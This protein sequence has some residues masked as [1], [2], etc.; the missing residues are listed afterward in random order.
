M[1][2]FGAH[3]PPE[4]LRPRIEA[5]LKPGCIVRLE[6]HFSQKTKPKYLVLVADDDPDYLTFIVNTDINKF[7]LARPALSQCQVTIDATSHPFLDH[8]SNVACHEVVPLKREDV[9]RALMADP[10][11]VKGEISDDVRAQILAAVKLAKTIDTEK[12]GKII[13]ALGA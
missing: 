13:A 10:L 3:L 1:S 4:L 2:S 11:E 5:A 6:M 12:K 8:D 9:I 7:I